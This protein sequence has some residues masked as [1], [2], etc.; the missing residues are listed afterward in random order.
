[1]HK[2]ISASWIAAALVLAPGTAL[3]ADQTIE[4]FEAGQQAAWNAHDAGTYAAAFDGGAQI[5]TSQGWH[6]TSQAEA[7]RNIGDGFKFVYAQAQLQLSDV[8]VRMLTQEL[9]SVTLSWAI[10]GA[11]TIDTGLPAGW[12]HGFE[13][14]VLQNR[15]TSWAVLAQ[16]DTV[17]TLTP[18]P[19]PATAPAQA[20]AQAVPPATFPTTAP[21]RATLH[22]GPRE[23]RLP[24]LREGEVNRTNASSAVLDQRNYVRR[25][26]RGLNPVRFVAG[27]I[28]HDQPPAGHPPASR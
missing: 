20:P 23:W 13:T 6:W 24:D 18:I 15:G 22:R 25:M 2:L 14:Q 9:A 4:D 28:V 16:Q 5:V 12:Q 1:M 19:A 7:A 11:R 27:Q 3:A 21:P 26:A 8:K 10:T 17:A